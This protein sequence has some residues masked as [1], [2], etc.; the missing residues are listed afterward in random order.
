VSQ[1]VAGHKNHE[2]CEKL[3]MDTVWNRR[4]SGLPKAERV[5]GDSSRETLILM[6]DWCSQ[7][8]NRNR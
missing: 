3:G 8:C 5:P 2:I 7:D 6:G 4:F 1:E